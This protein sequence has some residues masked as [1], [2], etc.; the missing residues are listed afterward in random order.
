MPITIELFF[1]IKRD[2]VMRLYNP[3]RTAALTRR[4]HTMG[5]TESFLVKSV[6]IALLLRIRSGQ[7][8]Q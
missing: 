5:H 8:C 3:E 6:S 7:T 4:S 2:D 1:S